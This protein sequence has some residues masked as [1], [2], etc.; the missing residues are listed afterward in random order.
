MMSQS[1]LTGFMSFSS[2]SGPRLPTELGAHLHTAVVD[3]TLTPGGK[4][5][6]HDRVDNR[7][8]RDVAHY[9]A[10]A[11][12]RAGAAHEVECVPV[13][14][15]VAPDDIGGQRWDD[16]QLIIADERVVRRCCRHLELAVPAWTPSASNKHRNR[17]A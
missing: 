7:V 16:V 10:C 2:I 4:T 3:T 13:N 12:V 15:G 5:R 11:L 6:A 9:T 17:R 14:D 8:G 1:S